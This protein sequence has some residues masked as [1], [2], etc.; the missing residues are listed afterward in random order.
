[1]LRPVA[2]RCRAATEA[3]PDC[4]VP[5]SATVHLGPQCRA[6]GGIG[7]VAE[8]CNQPRRP[9]N[10]VKLLWF[11]QPITDEPATH[12]LRGQSVSETLGDLHCERVGR[13][14]PAWHRA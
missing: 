7:A 8:S 13:I 14:A 9:M 4:L 1:M 11:T 12:C 10:P 2:G 6:G 3:G 5:G